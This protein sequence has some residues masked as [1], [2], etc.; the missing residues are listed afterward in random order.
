MLKR[1]DSI[2]FTKKN[3]VHPFE[4]AAS[5]NFWSEKNDASLFCVG[6]H[7]KK[8]PHDLVFARMFAG[9]VLDMVEVGVEMAQSMAE[10]KVR[11]SRLSRSVPSR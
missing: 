10:F 7:S 3:D 2:P 6:L 9:Q 1:P 4:D 5:L 8:R 11:L